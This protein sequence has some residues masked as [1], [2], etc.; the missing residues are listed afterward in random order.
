MS[1]DFSDDD[2]DA[3]E[4]ETEPE[5]T[6]A[7]VSASEPGTGTARPNGPADDLDHYMES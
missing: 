2:Y 4:D 1:G 6:K 5:T 3:V 7:A